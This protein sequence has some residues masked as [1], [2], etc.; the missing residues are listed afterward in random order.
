M[1]LDDAG[2]GK[3]CVPIGC[4]NCCAENETCRMVPEQ[5]DGPRY[6]LTSF[7][8]F[9]YAMLN[10]F[11]CITFDGW[12]DLLYQVLTYFYGRRNPPKLTF[13]FSEHVTIN[14]RTSYNQ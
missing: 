6:G 11:Q 13:T 7:D 2:E 1:V 12:S 8:N 9:G 14:E 4:S 3:L 10:I 5:Y